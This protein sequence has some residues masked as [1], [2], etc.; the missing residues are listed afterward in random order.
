MNIFITNTSPRYAAKNLNFYSKLRNKMI[1]ESAQIFFT[2]V[3]LYGLETPYRKTH[4]N[5]PSTTWARRSLENLLW[6]YDHLTYL[7]EEY[8]KN[9]VSFEK[10]KE[11]VANHSWRKHIPSKGLTLPHLAMDNDLQEDY[12]TRI[13]N[14]FKQDLFIFQSNSWKEAVIA[15]RKY[16]ERKEY[17]KDLKI[18][19]L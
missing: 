10:V 11:Y 1:L 18:E 3:N 15:Y 8:G 13:P 4:I 12:G 7:N 19:W 14:Q 9:H 5:H 2:V 16:L 17:A 6:L